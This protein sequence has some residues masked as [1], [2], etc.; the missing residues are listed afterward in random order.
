MADPINQS[1]RE[2][3][4]AVNASQAF[5]EEN[6]LIFQEVDLRND[7]GKD[8][9]LD[10]SRSGDDAG[11]CV[12]L[13]I[14]GGKKYKRG[15]GHSIPVSPRLRNI[16]RNSSI[17]IFVIVRDVLDG[18]LYWGDLTRMADTLPERSRTVALT[19]DKRL[20]P[21]GLDRFLEAARLACSV[22]RSDPLLNLTSRN[23]NLIQSALFDCLAA[24]RH[25]PRYLKL[26]RLAISAIDDQH[27]AWNAIHL[28]AH[29]T[30]HPDIFWHK[31][32]YIP[33]DIAK[34]IRTSYRWSPNEIAMLLARTPEGGWGRGT[35]E[36]S[37]YMILVADPSLDWSLERLIL[38]AFRT[39][40]LTW[41]GCWVKGPPFGPKWVRTEREAVIFSALA[42][43]LYRASD[44][45]ELLD[46]VIERI[47]PIQNIGMFAEIAE[48]V[49]E[50][51]Y[52]DIFLALSSVSIATEIATSRPPH[53][54]GPG[55]D[56]VRPGP[57]D[58]LNIELSRPGWK[59][60]LCAPLPAA[61]RRMRN[62]VSNSGI[63]G[64]GTGLAG[65]S[66]TR[67]RR[68]RGRVRIAAPGRS[69]AHVSHR[70]RRAGLKR[71]P[72][73]HPLHAVTT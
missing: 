28:L 16:W 36:Q 71:K 44:P 62:R 13:Q 2:E 43:I 26:V 69:A 53:K 6:G 20:T 12:A 19:P 68:A 72:A 23:P 66:L 25:D 37:L 4:R 7:I 1:R 9:I 57:D 61:L 18:Q 60:S 38:E 70:R 21:D 63:A 47:P 33:E 39:D 8:A 5:F 15:S 58:R 35:I 34:E 52:L 27:S 59:T 45:Q 73:K 11:L 24:G 50:F 29:A 17:P 46:E 48:I 30:S 49:A 40:E 32:N 55:S 41:R 65:A 67:P 64:P 10:L 3:R 22:R 51:N 31:G 56:V 54:V 42:L 14:K